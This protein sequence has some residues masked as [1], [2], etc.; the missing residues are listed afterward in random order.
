[1]APK[2][3]DDSL[4]GVR[5]ICGGGV[6]IVFALVARDLQKN[7]AQYFAS[8]PTTMAVCGT[9]W[10]SSGDSRKYRQRLAAFRLL[11]FAFQFAVLS[12]WISGTVSAGMAMCGG[13]E[14]CGGV[15]GLLQFSPLLVAHNT[16][17]AYMMQTAFWAIAATVSFSSLSKAGADTDEASSKGPTPRLRRIM[18]GLLS[19][20]LPGV[21]LVL[22]VEWGVILPARLIM[23]G[24]AESEL[25][26]MSYCMHG[27]NAACLFA[28]ACVDRLMLHPAAL[29]LLFLWLCIYIA[30]T[31]CQQAMYGT[32]P[33]FF[34]SLNSYVAVF[35]Y[36]LMFGLHR[37]AV[38]LVV[39]LD[40]LKERQQPS[41]RELQF[42]GGE[43]GGGGGGG[44]EAKK[45]PPT[46]ADSL[47]P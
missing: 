22:I 1:M 39:Q 28:E 38:A 14:Q 26:W 25:N 16:N 7:Y 30:N 27:V 18:H 43:G 47:M 2:P 4:L 33:Y 34:M 36:A 42:E 40:R 9:R 44:G 13:Y 11:V 6:F 12:T 41:L 29:Q 8:A 3:P 5:I 21:T 20:L 24:H 31:W 17:A 46:E 15:F 37:V 19:L 23:T 10:C 32:W 35:W 45:R